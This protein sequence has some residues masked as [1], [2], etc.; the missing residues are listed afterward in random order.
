MN[1][2]GQLPYI[3]IA[4]MASLCIY[5]I[6]FKSNLFKKMLAIFLLTDAVNL[7][8]IVQGYRSGNSIPPIIPPGMDPSEFA[9]LAVDPLAHYFVV[10]AVVIGLAEVATLT[11]LT[12]YTYRHYGTIE[13]RKIK[14]L[15]G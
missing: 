1:I 5:A 13:T 6:L 11:A 14:E 15:R 7:L 8:Y 3:L 4:M 10:T 9:S 2:A 12:I